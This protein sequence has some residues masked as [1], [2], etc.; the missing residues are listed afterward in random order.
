MWDDEKI[1]HGCNKGKRK[2]QAV[3]YDKYASSMRAIC[4]RYLGARPEAED[5]LHDALIKALSKI[6]QFN[7]KGSLEGWLK[8]I[9]M[10]T[11][12]DYLNKSKKLLFDTQTASVDIENI[13]EN[14]SEKETNFYVELSNQKIDKIKVLEVIKSL[15]DGYRA[16]L[17][18][19][20]IDGL[21]H[22]EISERLD[23]S[24]NTSKSQL[25]RARKMMKDKINELL[26]TTTHES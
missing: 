17:N 4:I 3:L 19:Y 15:P 11:S 23:I 1:I 10:T 8:R 18:M 2:A 24:V 14:E 16:I 7:Q 20:V 13:R 26:K 21:K 12:I 25:S 9:A 6:S 5:I 22:K